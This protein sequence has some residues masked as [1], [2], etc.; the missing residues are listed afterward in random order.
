MTSVE[1]PD[2]YGEVFAQLRAEVRSARSRALR[3][4]NTELIGCTGR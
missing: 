3:T 4:V 2:G 1:V